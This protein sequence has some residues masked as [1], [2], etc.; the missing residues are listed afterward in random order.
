[1]YQVKY[2]FRLTNRLFWAQ[3]WPLLNRA[4]FLEAA[5]AVLK[6]GSSL[7]A[8]HHWEIQSQICQTFCKTLR[9]KN[10]SANCFITSRFSYCSTARY[11]VQGSKTI[12]GMS[13]DIEV[14][15][16]DI[17]LFGKLVQI[18]VVWNIKIIFNVLKDT[19][20]IEQCGIEFLP[21]GSDEPDGVACLR[22][23]D[24]AFKLSQECRKVIASRPR[25]RR[26]RYSN[27]LNDDAMLS[28]SNITIWCFL[29]MI[30][31]N[32][33]FKALVS[34]TRLDRCVCPARGN[35]KIPCIESIVAL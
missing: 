11:P 4:V 3:F 23:N 29:S 1:M 18:V 7:K 15:V 26:I 17:F 22:S 10:Q 2:G 34:N 6:I 20:D 9:V 31:E 30:F 12:S 5:G 35:I 19:D 32:I 8:N 14:L 16:F 27:T 28:V 21:D 24:V 25:E 33:Y 13:P